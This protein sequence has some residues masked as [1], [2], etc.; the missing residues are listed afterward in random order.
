MDLDLDTIKHLT[1]VAY[2]VWLSVDHSDT[3]RGIE[4]VLGKILAPCQDEE[5]QEWIA[6]QV[7]AGMGNF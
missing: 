2:E 3:E 6:Q 1:D 5:T 7:I 4:M